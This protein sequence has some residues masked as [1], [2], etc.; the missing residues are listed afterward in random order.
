MQSN[1]FRGRQYPSAA[2]TLIELLVVIAIIGILLS[3]LIP[4]LGKA[5]KQV[6]AVVCRSNLHQIGLAVALYADANQNYIPR[7]NPDNPWFMRFLPYLGHDQQQKDYR[8][9]RIYKCPDF[10]RTGVGENNISNANQTLCYVVSSWTFNNRSDTIGHEIRVETKL[11][12]F[13]HPGSTIYMADHEDGPW[14]P[15]IQTADDGTSLERCDIWAP[16]HLPSSTNQ[17]PTWGRRIA[18]ARHRDGC[19]VLFLDYHSEYIPADAMTVDMWRD[20]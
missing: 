15:I 4:A 19:N 7:G 5:K 2:F 17:D 14:R 8:D 16:T 10:P 1:R 12:E 9:V 3:V 18:R 20:K 6:R 13:R 11:S